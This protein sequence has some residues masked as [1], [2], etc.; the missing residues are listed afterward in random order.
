MLQL[1][2]YAILC[3][4]RTMYIGW[5]LCSC[6]IILRFRHFCCLWRWICRSRTRYWHIQNHHST[7]RGNNLRYFCISSWK[8]FDLA[9]WIRNNGFTTALNCC[10]RDRSSSSKSLILNK[11]V[12]EFLRQPQNQTDWEKKAVELAKNAPSVQAWVLLAISHK[13]S[14]QKTNSKS[15]KENLL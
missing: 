12:N 9:I 1:E 11:V 8:V 3:L 5:V 10:S 6:G 13:I 14:S 4:F 7:I 2:T 15:R